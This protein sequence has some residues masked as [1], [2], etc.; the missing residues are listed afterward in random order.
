MAR[1]RREAVRLIACDPELDRRFRLMLTTIGIAET[2]A[3]QI[4]GELAVLPT[5]WTR[6]SGWPSADWIR[7]SSSRGNRSRSGHGL[8]G[9]AVV[10]CVVL[11]TCRP[12]SHCVVIP[13]SV[14]SIKTCSL[15]AKLG[16]KRWWQSCGNCCMLCLPCLRSNQPYDGSKLCTVH[17]A[18]HAITACA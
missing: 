16:C 15:V 12:R 5:C 17:L 4:L 6:A 14:S 3:L 11:C 18:V 9:V 8:A 13:I 7:G 2:S 10:T 1:L